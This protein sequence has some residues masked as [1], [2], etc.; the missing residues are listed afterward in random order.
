M[1]DPLSALGFPAKVENSEVEAFF[2]DASSG[3]AKWNSFFGRHCNGPWNTEVV[4]FDHEAAEVDT[5]D[6]HAWRSLVDSAPEATAAWL[7]H[8]MRFE[9][10]ASPVQRTVIVLT[11]AALSK[12]HWHE[13][14]RAELEAARPTKDETD[15]FDDWESNQEYLDHDT[16]YDTCLAD[17]QA[18]PSALIALLTRI[19]DDY[20]DM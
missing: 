6:A 15:D 4:Y 9:E 20:L 12:P 17:W 3:A 18:S 13:L 1:Q 8:G 10:Y 5:L 14:V 2:R 16:G 7:R 11:F 19:T